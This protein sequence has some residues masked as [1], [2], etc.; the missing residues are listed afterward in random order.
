MSYKSIAIWLC[1]AACGIPAVA[2]DVY[3]QTDFSS[4]IPEGYTLLD[5]DENPTMS[6]MKNISFAGGSWV[7]SLVNSHTDQAA[8]SSSYCTYDYDVEDWL[9]TPQIHIASADAVLR[10][11]AKSVH[12]DY[13]EQYRVLISQAGTATADFVE[14]CTVSAEDYEWRTRALPL[15]EYAGKDV[16]IAFVHGGRSGFMLAV[17]NI[18]VGELSSP[19]YA[20]DNRTVVTAQGGGDVMVEGFVRNLS[21]ARTVV[22]VCEA[23]GTRYTANVADA[24]CT[25]GDSVAFSFA[26][27]APAEGKIAYRVGVSEGNDTLWLANDTVYCSAFKRNLLLEE[28]TAIWC[29]NCPEGIMQMNSYTHRFRD[30]VI[31]VVAH[32]NYSD[33]MGDDNYSAGMNYWL[34]NMPSF[35]YDRLADYKSQEA[36]EDGNI[37]KALARPVT[38]EI[39]LHTAEMVGDSTLRVQATVRCATTLDNT[40]DDYRVAFIVS[41]NMVCVDDKSYNQRNNCT[42]PTDNEYYYLPT[43]IPGAKMRYHN[44]ARGLPAAFT[45]EPGLLPARE[46]VTG[47]DYEVEY[48]FRLPSSVL[49]MQNISIIA[50]L[51]TL[52]S[53]AV[54][55]ASRATSIDYS[56]NVQAVTAQADAYRMVATGEGVTVTALAGNA[57]SA[58][59]YGIDGRVVS[60]ARGRGEVT[61]ATGNT[62]GVGIVAVTDDAGNSV[63]KKILLNYSQQ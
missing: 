19:C 45:G 39:D 60:V 42:M 2:D 11:D 10:W 8:L 23:D 57:F 54:L 28:Y 16:Y 18:T 44:V 15:G 55:N 27:P 51:L 49:D 3:L 48:S 40:G 6:G 12:Y 41:E 33:V 5:K 13:R 61:L 59:L 30:A 50:V 4:G 21:T 34:N 36:R 53:R 31:P 52:P 58:T 26:V 35:L 22:P 63:Y 14:L 24:P 9:I 43:I 47:E 20:A 1:L 46:L 32:S 17:D 25:P 56:G 38:A 37:Y 62:C 7:A 29:T